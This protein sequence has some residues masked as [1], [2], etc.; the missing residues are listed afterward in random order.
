MIFKSHSHN[1]DKIEKTHKENMTRLL[2]ASSTIKLI[3]SLLIITTLI[4]YGCNYLSNC[5]NEEIRHFSD[6]MLNG[7]FSSLMLILGYIAGTRD[8]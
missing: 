2:I 5:L 7:L 3:F 6:K 4:S 1:P 8:N